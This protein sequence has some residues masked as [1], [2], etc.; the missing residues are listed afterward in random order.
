MIYAEASYFDGYAFAHIAAME[1]HARIE[2]KRTAA[3]SRY[4]EKRPRLAVALTTATVA[5]IKLVD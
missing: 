5:A 1:E 4:L 3:R 2:R